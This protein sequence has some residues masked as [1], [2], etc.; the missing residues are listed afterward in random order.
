[1][2]V[3]SIIIFTI[4]LVLI[5]GGI[6]VYKNSTKVTKQPKNIETLKT[7]DWITYQNTAF[8]YSIKHPAGLTNQSNTADVGVTPAQKD[9]RAIIFYNKDSREPY[10][11]R[12]IDL[13]VFQADVSSKNATEVEI[14]GIKMKKE[15]LSEK[16]LFSIYTIQ[17]KTGDYLQV[18]ISNDVTRKDIAFEILNTFN[19][20]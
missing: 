4:I 9:S 1:M 8:R 15:P 7:K 16:S 3:K 6:L 11:E 13:E 20:N 18:M 14:N 2:K 17:L 19:L 10:L 12:Y 5:I